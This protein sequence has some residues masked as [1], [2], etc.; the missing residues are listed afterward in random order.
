MPAE[1]IRFFERLQLYY[2][3]RDCVCSHGG[4]DPRVI[5]LHQQPRNAF[6]WGADSFPGGYFGDEIVVYGHRDDASL[7]AN[8]WPR[9]AT[10]GRTIGIDTISHGVLTA[11][12][13]PDQRLF[14]SARH[15]ET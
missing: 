14:Q 9:P 1:H 7:D 3:G 10:A 4:L 5:H 15:T 6:L 11:I 13:L 8:G 12:R 2:Q